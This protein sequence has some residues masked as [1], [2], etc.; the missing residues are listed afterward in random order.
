VAK[1]RTAFSYIVDFDRTRLKPNNI[2]VCDQG[3]KIT[4]RRKFAS[5]SHKKGSDHENTYPGTH[6]GSNRD[7][8]TRWQEPSS[9]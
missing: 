2:D 1:D 5:Y 7:P 4:F 8:I 3:F 6:S 9:G